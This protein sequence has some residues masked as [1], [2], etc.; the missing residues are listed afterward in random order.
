MLRLV[1]VAVRVAHMKGIGHVQWIVIVVC[2]GTIALLDCTLVAQQASVRVG[3]ARV[4]RSGHVCCCCCCSVAHQHGVALVDVAIAARVEL[5]VVWQKD[6]VIF[7]VARRLKL[8]LVPVKSL[9][10]GIDLQLAWVLLMVVAVCN[11]LLLQA[12]CRLLNGR[13]TKASPAPDCIVRC[14]WSAKRA[15]AIDLV[16]VA[17]SNTVGSLGLTRRR[18][19]ELLLLLSGSLL[20]R[21]G[22]RRLRVS[23]NLDSLAAWFSS[24]RSV[25]VIWIYYGN[26]R[27]V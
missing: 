20:A 24:T 6:V 5:V 21:L 4:S 19:L 15:L 8:V 12:D 13:P 18:Q 2:G 26:N 22:R 14:I 9:I 27:L 17:V 3:G 16:V 7:V 11:K 25:L 23:C 1:L 10:T